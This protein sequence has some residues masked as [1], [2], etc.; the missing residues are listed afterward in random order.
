VLNS[1]D[2]PCAQLEFSF[3]E[4]YDATSMHDAVSAFAGCSLSC[5]GC[6]LLWICAHTRV[7]SSAEM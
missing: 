4:L 7:L 5:A 6:S 2:L 1:F 3:Q